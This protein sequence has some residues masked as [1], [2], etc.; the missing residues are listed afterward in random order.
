MPSGLWHHQQDKGHPLKKTVTLI[1]GPS[2]MANRFMSK[3]QS[4]IIIWQQNRVSVQGV[5]CDLGKI[6]CAMRMK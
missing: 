3:M 6:E 4:L 5:G 2:W 1:P